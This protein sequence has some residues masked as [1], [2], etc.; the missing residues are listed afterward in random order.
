MEINIPGCHRR[1]RTGGEN[2]L[3]QGNDIKLKGE[4][5]HIIIYFFINEHLKSTYY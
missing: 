1:C 3:D 4:L 2:S 5:N